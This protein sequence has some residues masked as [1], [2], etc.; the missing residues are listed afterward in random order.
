PEFQHYFV[1]FGR[2]SGEKGVL[3]LLKALKHIS[4]RSVKLW[5]VGEGPEKE[6]LQ[7]F[8]V[9]NKLNQVQFLGL[10]VGEELKSLVANA[11]FVVVPSEWYE[12]SPLVIYEAFALGKPVI[13]SNLGGIPELIDPGQNGWLFEARNEEDLAEK[14]DYFLHH[15]A[16]IREFG[17]HA[18]QKAEA[19]FSPEGHYQKMMEFYKSIQVSGSLSETNGVDCP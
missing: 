18:R 3:T 16:T 17:K 6:K 1:Y 9:E 2:L 7:R 13:G 15:P 4:N 14:I 8:A 10:K 5:I 12:N 11:M 19:C